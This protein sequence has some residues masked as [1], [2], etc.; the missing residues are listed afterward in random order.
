MTTGPLDLERVKSVT[1]GEFIDI[2]EVH[3][4]QIAK[5]LDP[6]CSSERHIASS[7]PCIL[8]SRGNLF[9]KDSSAL[10]S[11]TTNM[12]LRQRDAVI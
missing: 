9:S 4:I 10:S 3:A 12:H 8:I 2:F 5:D 1:M 7:R 6:V 11:P